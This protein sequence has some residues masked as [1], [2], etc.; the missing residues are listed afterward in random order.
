MLLKAFSQVSHISISCHLWALSCV[1]VCVRAHLQ[2]CVHKWKASAHDCV[3]Y[4]RYQDWYRCVHYAAFLRQN[5]NVGWKMASQCVLLVWS[6]IQFHN[7]CYKWN[8]HVCNRTHCFPLKASQLDTCW[9]TSQ[10]ISG[11][12]IW[13]PLTSCLT[14]P[15]AFSSTRQFKLYFCRWSQVFFILFYFTSPLSP[16]TAPLAYIQHVNRLIVWQ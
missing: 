4:L 8:T 10:T 2:L 14:S 12:S 6:A 1:C 16:K 15:K 9:P 3:I 11:I 5:E 7:I 13:F